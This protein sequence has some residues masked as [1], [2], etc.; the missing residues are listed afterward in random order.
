M[1][2]TILPIIGLFAAVCC[3]RTSDDPTSTAQT[4]LSTPVISV[5]DTSP[6]NVDVPAKISASAPLFEKFDCLR[7]FGALPAAHRGGPRR[8]YPENAIET[9][10]KSFENGA[11]IF[12]VDVAES[13]DGV[14]F[15][16]HDDDLDRTTARTGPADQVRWNELDTIF[17]TSFDTPTEFTIPSLI[18]ALEWAKSN[19]AVLELDKKRSTQFASIIA[20][21]RKANAENNVILITYSYAQAEEVAQLAPDLMLTASVDEPSDIDELL[22]RGV[23]RENLIAWTGTETIN[24]ELWQAINARGVEVAFGTLGRRGERLDDVFNQD[25]DV[26]EYADLANSGVQLIATDFSDRV[27]RVLD[28]ENAIAVC[29]F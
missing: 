3:S 12:E 26:S 4:E 27:S 9:M 28:D 18:E 17:L 5:V 8:G 16:L 20:D 19:N 11:R 6:K 23:K 2:R 15:L 29:G 7:E 25:R 22:A 13:K 14:L 21:V 24:P 1:K 10:Q